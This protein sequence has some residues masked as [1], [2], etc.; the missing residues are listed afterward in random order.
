MSKF[1]LDTVVLRVFAFAHPQGIEILLTA[2]KTSQVSFP[3][4][5]YNQD[6]DNLPLNVSDENLSELA[7]GIRYARRQTQNLPGLK[8][9]RFQTRLENATQ[10]PRYL[11]TGNLLI[12][13]LELLELSQRENL[14]KNYGIGCG[15]AA[16]LVLAQ[17]ES[18]TAIFLSSDDLA[19]RASQI[20]GI[21]FLT[22]PD[23]LTAWVRQN[24][25]TIDLLQDLIEGMRNA[26][27][28]LPDNDY[29]NLQAILQGIS[30]Q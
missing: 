2:L 24:Q 22:I 25:P 12:E 13:P 3:A 18:S 10:I 9:Q 30:H 29:E 15:E 19:C 21:S 27:F 14:I 26:N 6:E 28:V 23:I 7:R 4:E 17:R 1:V 8:G 20:L 11:Q 5:V 16:C